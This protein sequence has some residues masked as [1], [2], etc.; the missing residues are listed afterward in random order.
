MTQTK[1]KETQGA[2]K[3]FHDAHTHM[4]NRDTYVV[5]LSCGTK[6][7]ADCPSSSSSSMRLSFDRL[8]FSLSL[9][10]DDS[11]FRTRA[12]DADSWVRR[13]ATMATNELGDECCVEADGIAPLDESGW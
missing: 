4:N 5:D 1:G 2:R 13:R 8:R 7:D 3:T 10:D 6:P 11:R 9:D 12:S